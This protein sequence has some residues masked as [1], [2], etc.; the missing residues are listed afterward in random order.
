[1]VSLFSKWLTRFFKRDREADE[2]HHL[3]QHDRKFQMGRMPL[4][5]PSWLATGLQLLETP[6]QKKKRPTSR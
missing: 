2:Q 4:V 5:T 3:D 6:E 1:M